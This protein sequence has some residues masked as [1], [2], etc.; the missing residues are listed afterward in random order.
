MN[1]TAKRIILTGPPNSGKTTLF[2]W[3]TGFRHRVVNYPGS[4]VFLSVGSLLDKYGLSADVTDSPG[5]YSLFPRSDDEKIAVQA[6]FKD[7]K[8]DLVILVLDEGK[9]EIQLPLLF[10]LKEAGFSAVTALTMR[11][12]LPPDDLA[13]LDFLSQALKTPVVSVDGLSGKGLY[14][15]TQSLKNFWGHSADLP[16][17]NPPEGAGFVNAPAVL[18]SQTFAKRA[19]KS[20][21]SPALASPSFAKHAKP[22]GAGFVSSP[23]VASQAFAKRANKSSASPALASPSFAKHAKL[24]MTAVVRALAVASQVFIRRAKPKD[25]DFVN[26]QTSTEK[27]VNKSVASSASDSK[28]IRQWDQKT[29]SLALARSKQLV[30]QAKTRRRAAQPVFTKDNP[31]YSHRWDRLFLHPVKG[32]FLFAG[33]MTA[34]FYSIFWLA[35]PFM[36]AVDGLFSF[37]T[38]QTIERLSDWPR[39]ADFIG[40]GLL[41]SFG[42]VLIFV[43]QIFI[44]FAGIALL[45]GSGYLARAVALMDGPLSKI[46]LS[47]RAFVPFLSGFACA[48]PAILSARN[49]RSRREKL[50][51]FFAVPFMTCSARLPVYALL[52]SFLF[53]GQS[54]WKPGLSLSLIYIGSFLLGALAVALLNLFLRKE[55]HD[56]FL[57]DL[58][59]YRRPDF[60]KIVRGAMRRTRHYVVKA[61]PAVFTVALLIWLL[62]HLPLAPGLSPAERIGQ[63]YAGQIGRVAQPL[64]ELMG[65][66]WRVGLALIAAFAAREVFVSALILVFSIGRAGG[67]VSLLQ[68]MQTAVFADGSPVFTTASVS[69]LTVFFM[70]SL[71][72]LSTTAVVYKESGSFKLA[73]AQ[74]AILNVLAWVMA[75]LTYQSLHFLGL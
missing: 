54:A 30:S 2:N 66:D 18:S 11:D 60:A 20:S 52:L 32:L 31:F 49:F 40:N 28:K 21:A 4:T 37:L 41:T 68:S 72:C 3:L 22:K 5:I 74:L 19:N 43:P 15:L 7:E 23:A 27:R 51:T 46:G 10:Q 42:A 58:P 47:G 25:A 35:A 8:P 33:I 9:L 69:A 57:L 29:L 55:D 64:F 17:Q 59:L 44:L 63:S 53:Y 71:Q 45:E 75:V 16:Q 6:L 67:G 62:T 39:L 36:T 65:V 13:D 70:F 14:D 48:I 56:V 61:G 1:I 12:T 73:F 26:R 50:M 34:L 24:Q 38:A